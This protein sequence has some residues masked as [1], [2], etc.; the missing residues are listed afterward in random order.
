M[1][2]DGAC[3]SWAEIGQCD[4]K[5]PKAWTSDV[6][7]LQRNWNMGNEAEFPLYEMKMKLQFKRAQEDLNKHCEK[8]TEK[9]LVR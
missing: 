5:D 4:K 1:D 6:H 2:V 3:R 7:S 8:K 9:S